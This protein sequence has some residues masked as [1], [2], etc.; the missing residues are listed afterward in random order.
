[1]TVFLCVAMAMEQKVALKCSLT[2]T[3]CACMCTSVQQIAFGGR[4][5]KNVQVGAHVSARKRER[6][7]VHIRLKEITADPCMN[8]VTAEFLTQPL[9]LCVPTCVS[10]LTHI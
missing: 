4:H 8:N 3:L 2:E 5:Q 10:L 7:C 6:V 1:M 9:T